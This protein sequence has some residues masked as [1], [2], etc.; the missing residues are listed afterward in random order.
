MAAVVIAIVYAGAALLSATSKRITTD[1]EFLSS[2]SLT[3]HTLDRVATGA[4]AVLATPT[5]IFAGETLLRKGGLLTF[6]WPHDLWAYSLA[7]SGL[8]LAFSALYQFQLRFLGPTI[9]VIL[10]WVV[11]P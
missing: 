1:V 7:G 11:S 10:A 2:S 3:S 8:M 5:A 6:F 4:L 9:V